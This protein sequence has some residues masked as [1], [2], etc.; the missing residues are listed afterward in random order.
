MASE[1]LS[2][3]MDELFFSYNKIETYQGRNTRIVFFFLEWKQIHLDQT[4][5]FEE[6][7]F[8]NYNSV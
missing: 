1:V 2:R 3:R 8:E 7:K 6:I 4:E 5:F